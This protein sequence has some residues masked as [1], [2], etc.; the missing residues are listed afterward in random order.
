MHAPE[1]NRRPGRR[2][3]GPSPRRWAET[4]WAAVAAAG[5]AVAVMAG[6]GAPAPSAPTSLA[7]PALK[8]ASADVA[9]GWAMTVTSAD[10]KVTARGHANFA[11]F[12]LQKGETLDLSVAPAGQKVV[13]EGTLAVDK[14]GPHR[15][16]M[17]V[18]GGKA[19]IR[20][21]GGGKEVATASGAG[22]ASRGQPGGVVTNWAE[23]VPDDYSVLIEF[24]R[25][26]DGPARLRT[27]WEKQWLSEL[28]AGLDQGFNPE[29]IPTAAVEA[30]AARAAATELARRGRTLLGELGCVN[31]H[32][33][34][35][36]GRA[37][38]SGRQG[39]MLGEIARRASAD[40]VVKWI[41][42]PTQIKPKTHM[43]DVIGDGLNEPNEAVN[44]T[45][46][47]MSVG[48]GDP[49][50]AQPLAT[51]E[52][53]LKRGRELYH[54]LGCV[55]CHGAY[56][57]P[58]AVFGDTTQPDVKPKNAGVPAP[59]GKLAGK[60]R[61]EAL[62]EFLLDPL[63]VHPSG[64]M[65]DM[66]LSQEEADFVTRYLISRWDAEA[67]VK[68]KPGTFAVDAGRAALGRTAFAVKGCADCHTLGGG[69]PEAPSTLKAKPLAELA[70]GAGCTDPADT[71]S[72][73]FAFA[74]GDLK[75]L[76]AGLDSVKAAVGA[77]S[78]LDKQ[79]QT[80]VAFNCRAC[81][82]KDGTGGIRAGADGLDAFFKTVG[83]Q[84]ELGDEG[85]LPPE[86]TLVGWKLT[87][88]WLRQVLMEAGR[89]RPYM[90]AHMPQFGEKNVGELVRGL[91]AHDG[92]L[93]DTDAEEPKPSD[94]LVAAGR[95]LVGDKGLNCIAC[96]VWGDLPPAGTAGP[97]IAQFGQRLRF[98]WW[99]SYILQPKR[100]K[101]GTRM[102]E[103]FLPGR[104]S[105]VDVFGGDAV[106]QPEALWAYFQLGK[107]APA[108]S[109][110]GAKG[111]DVKL[112]PEDRPIVFRSFLQNAGS[113]GIAV[114]YPAGV[115]FEFD[116]GAVRLVDAW[117]GD[118]MDA[119][120]AWKGRGGSVTGGQGKTV[121]TAPKG[122]AIVV[123]AD[124][125]KTWPDATGADAGMHFK[126]YVLDDKGVPTFEYSLKAGD[127]T[128]DVRERFT[129]GAKGESLFNRIFTVSG[130]K[131]TAFWVN[132][133]PGAVVA[134]CRSPI[135]TRMADGQTWVRVMSFED[136]VE[137]TLGVT[138]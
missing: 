92:V 20:V 72:P 15:F 33:A 23:L 96:H 19:V 5:L 3:S 8:G 43:P 65:P 79:E 74:E 109:G 47:L 71:A 108:P 132:G 121:W 122:P 58:R 128:L 131:G 112:T 38:V 48:G 101:P 97:N 42:N 124:P 115:H 21:V 46:Y 18:E 111:S 13:F 10:G 34:G 35:E 6:V 36:K 95:R 117:R 119:S 51:E 55:A 4:A 118:F 32:D 54:T 60:W 41:A 9:K 40:W 129:P 29:P 53:G 39:P 99:R 137:L 62:R 66:K 98:D 104:S 89:A 45:H 7:A 87:S 22:V 2:A 50:P 61:P 64:R 116:A 16:A 1:L 69:R 100:F 30:P 37:A 80:V 52:A 93:P 24:T 76:A 94:E 67:A 135:Q 49:G 75:A 14:T 106:K 26:G 88:S 25:T 56:E 63:R 113:R 12:A 126:G 102:S 44:I 28:R 81:H 90:S 103:F 59:H 133:G 120:G 68:P 17:D 11:S 86:L 105:A 84:T 83:E 91:A 125:P 114:G 73:R 110:L 130:A 85:R 78:P 134:A 82:A 27:V 127:K 70:F 136:Q 31:C 77:V 123:A 57:S 107:I 138:P